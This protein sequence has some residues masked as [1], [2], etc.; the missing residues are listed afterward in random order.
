MIIYLDEVSTTGDTA[1][2]QCELTDYSRSGW[3]LQKVK[4]KLSLSTDKCSHL[5]HFVN[6][7]SGSNG[8]AIGTACSSYQDFSNSLSLTIN[9][10]LVWPRQYTAQRKTCMQCLV[11][12]NHTKLNR[13][14]AQLLSGFVSGTENRYLRQHSPFDLRRGRYRTRFSSCSSSVSTVVFASRKRPLG[15]PI[16]W[17][18]R[19]KKKK[20]FKV[21]PL[22]SF[23]LCLSVRET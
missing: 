20:A 1:R 19:F 7:A 17:L 23:H 21:V 18:N 15:R 10:H 8:S 13:P 12:H 22:F 9:V 16:L 2:R 5:A 14:F 11:C 4:K 3:V 6:F